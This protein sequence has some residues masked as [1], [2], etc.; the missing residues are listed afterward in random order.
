MKSAL[1]TGKTIGHVVTQESYLG[2]MFEI[3]GDVLDGTLAVA[4][5]RHDSETYSLVL[6]FVFQTKEEA[7]ELLDDLKGAEKL[8][9]MTRN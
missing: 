7:V 4:E 8:R 2:D 5:I 3:V 9:L 1:G 6:E